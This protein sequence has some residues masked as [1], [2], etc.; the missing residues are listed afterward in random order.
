MQL[1]TCLSQIKNCGGAE[2]AFFE[3]CKCV[4]VKREEI[5]GFKGFAV[6][7]DEQRVV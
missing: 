6:L 3:N 4:F 1:S 2:V 5:V 7:Y